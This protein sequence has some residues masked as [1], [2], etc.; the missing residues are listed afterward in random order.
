MT[1]AA[2]ATTKANGSRIVE[3]PVRLEREATVRPSVY[4]AMIVD[5]AT[6]R[7]RPFDWRGT[8]S[9]AHALAARLRD[10]GHLVVVVKSAE[11]TT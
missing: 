10:D 4:L 7:R 3:K 8:R 2:K 1:T 5:P 11:V 9:E 6:G